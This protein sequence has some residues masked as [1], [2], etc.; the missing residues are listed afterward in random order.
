MQGKIFQNRIN[1]H[2]RLV[3]SNRIPFPK[4]FEQNN[5]YVAVEILFDVGARLGEF[6]L[7]FPAR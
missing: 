3:K 6:D 1:D 2:E 7:D 5:L 4:N